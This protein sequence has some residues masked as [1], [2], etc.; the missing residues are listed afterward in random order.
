M[1]RVTMGCILVLIGVVIAILPASSATAGSRRACPKQR[2]KD[3]L[4][5]PW[6]W[7]VVL[8]GRVS[9]REANRTNRRYLRALR[10]GRCPTRICSEVTFPGGW[11]CSA[12]SPVEEQ[13]LGNGEVGGCRRRGAHFEVFEVTAHSSGQGDRRLRQFTP[14]DRKVW[15]AAGTYPGSREVSCGT[16]P[17]PPTHSA[18]VDMHGLVSLCSALRT[19][20]PPGSKVPNGCFQNWPL[21][22][23][24]VPVLRYGQRTRLAGFLCSSDTSG[25]SCTLWTGARSG[26][27]FRINKDETIKVG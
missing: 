19:E 18:E 10:E 13:E 4:G 26:K 11:T 1:K 17:E 27:G 14:P 25:I 23:D 21:P 16:E 9:C 20:Y 24:H 5:R 22:G 3:A 8:H 15:C 12:L 2:S 7:R 6:T